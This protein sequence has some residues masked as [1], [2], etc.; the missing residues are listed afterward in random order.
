[1]QHSDNTI[2]ELVLDDGASS[3]SRRTRDIILSTAA[4]CFCEKTYSKVRI[5]DIA[6]R[7]GV[8]RALIYSY[9]PSKQTLLREAK[10]RAL[11]MW[12][13]LSAIDHDL[14]TSPGNAHD[15]L[16]SVVRSSFDYIRQYPI[17]LIVMSPDMQTSDPQWR[18]LALEAMQRWR[19][20]LITLLHAGLR[21]GDFVTGLDVEATADMI[22]TLQAG[23]IERKLRGD[24]YTVDEERLI[25]ASLDIL[26]SGIRQR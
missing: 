10:T 14:D 12:G 16:V 6:E 9:F 26:I 13:S 18:Q 15:K 19:Q 4:V 1:M 3:K 7:A 2:P 21:S 24:P 22:R 5:E 23:I 11:E 8:S 17:T 25:G 20:T